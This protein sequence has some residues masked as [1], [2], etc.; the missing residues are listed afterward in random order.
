MVSHSYSTIRH[1]PGLLWSAMILQMS[2]MTGVRSDEA[3]TISNTEAASS[4]LFVGLGSGVWD[5]IF[6]WSLVATLVAALLVGLAA[7]GSAITHRREAVIA[8]RDLEQRSQTSPASAEA[9]GAGTNPADQAA[10]QAAGQKSGRHERA[11]STAEGLAS[12][13]RPA[14]P[15]EPQSQPVQGSVPADQAPGEAAGQK[16]SQPEQAAST[17]EGLA[18]PDRPAQSDKL[19]PQPVQGPIPADQAAGEATGRKPSRPERAAPTAERLASRET[20]AQSGK[21][22]PQPVQGSVPVDRRKRLRN[23]AISVEA[24]RALTR[25][26]KDHPGNVSVDYD[27]VDIQTQPLG[28]QL[29]DAFNDAGWNVSSGIMLGISTPP[30]SGI[31]I[32]GNS[33]GLTASQER[34]VRAF[35]TAGIPF[36]LRLDREP[37]SYVS[38][39]AHTPFGMGA[40]DV[41]IVITLPRH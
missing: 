32:R 33:H 20:P 9:A 12:P 19:R 21:P 14:Q 17:A 18:S 37:K 2:I 27:G 22:R 25:E 10:S 31:L 13:D 8:K 1:K 7:A 34:A 40:D 11:A 4:A 5:R 6:F 28:V 16:P 41:E 24:A 38:G 35:S 39:Q 23:A 36:D 29:Q 30:K 15:D 3:H 26:L